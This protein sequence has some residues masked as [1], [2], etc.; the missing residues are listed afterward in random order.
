MK[1]NIFYELVKGRLL[2]A[3]LKGDFVVFD[4]F[5]R[6]ARK[7]WNIVYDDSVKNIFKFF[8]IIC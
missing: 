3:R 5:I 1:V 6:V 4:I 2:D 8:V 7:C